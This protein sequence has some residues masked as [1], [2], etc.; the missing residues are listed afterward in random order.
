M[1]ALCLAEGIALFTGKDFL[2][3]VGSTK[4]EDYDLDK[5]FRVEKWVFTADAACSFGVGA[6]R[7]P[8][9]VEAIL[10]AVF[11]A[12]C[13]STCMCLRAGSSAVMND[14]KRGLLPHKLGQ[15]LFWLSER[16]WL[17]I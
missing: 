11:G 7:L 4:K 8:G 3:F 16:I 13:S 1:G 17:D 14:S 5:V 10:L 6:N 15:R 9:T 12:T 2:M